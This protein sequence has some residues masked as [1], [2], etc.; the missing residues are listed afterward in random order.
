M[1]AQQRRI[2]GQHLPEHLV[3]LLGELSSVN[4]SIVRV[5]RAQHIGKRGPRLAHHRRLSGDHIGNDEL[6]RFGRWRW[7][8]TR[9]SSRGTRQ[10]GL[11][12]HRLALT[13]SYVF[14][15]RV[16]RLLLCR[17]VQR[18]D[19]LWRRSF[20]RQ[21]IALSHRITQCRAGLLPR[22]T[23]PPLVWL[24]WCAAGGRLSNHP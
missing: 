2:A 23:A 24:S 22:R 1:R 9:N 17:A 6:R 20:R 21:T 19:A 11:R 5:E 15:E 10:F 3:L 7:R 8:G 14:P 12:L 4:T 16:E 13:F 18:L